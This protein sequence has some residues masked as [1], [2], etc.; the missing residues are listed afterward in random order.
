VIL[1]SLDVNFEHLVLWNKM[2]WPCASRLGLA[3]HFERKKNLHTTNQHER[4]VH[5]PV[6]ALNNVGSCTVSKARLNKL[7]SWK[8]RPC[9]NFGCVII[10]QDAHTAFRLPLLSSSDWKSSQRLVLFQFSDRRSMALW[11]LLTRGGVLGCLGLAPQR[12]NKLNENRPG[13]RI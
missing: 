9:M 5:G 8:A 1:A 10:F 11:A 4:K 13:S 6:P 7:I 2:K 3:P 12:P